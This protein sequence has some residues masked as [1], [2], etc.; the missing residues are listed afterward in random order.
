MKNS[1]QLFFAIFSF[2]AVLT[3]SSCTEITINKNDSQG[4]CNTCPPD[5]GNGGVIIEPT[6]TFLGVALSDPSPVGTYRATNGM[7]IELS[8]TVFCTES[9]GDVLVHLTPSQATAVAADNAESGAHFSEVNIVAGQITALNGAVIDV[10]LISGTSTESQFGCW[11]GKRP[12]SPEPENPMSRAD[13]LEKAQKI[14]AEDNVENLKK[15]FEET[16]EK[17]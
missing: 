17:K 15:L 11:S 6:G 7:E 16:T 13:Q 5:D 2:V 4:G 12:E 9:F 14:A 8:S 10:W 3:F 1:K